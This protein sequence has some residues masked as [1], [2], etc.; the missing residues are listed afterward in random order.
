MDNDTVA[1]KQRVTL[2]LEPSLVRQMK[3]DAID[4]DMNLSEHVEGLLMTVVEGKPAK[5]WG[6]K[7]APDDYVDP[8][9]QEKAKY[10]PRKPTDKQIK[11]LGADKLRAMGYE[12]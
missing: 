4:R 7:D 3:H 5:V 1:T 9:E 11:L 2:Y 10:R 6:W 12:C 8:L